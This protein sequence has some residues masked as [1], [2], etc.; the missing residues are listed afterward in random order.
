MNSKIIDEFER[1]IAFI[2]NETDKYITE[3]DTKAA[4]RN[5]FRIRQLS[6]V[7]GILKKYPTKLT[8]ENFKELDDIP[9][10]GKGSINRIKEILEDGKLSEIG[11]FVDIKK[12]K[13]KSLEALEE[14]VGVGRSKALELYNQGI[15]DVKILKQ[16]IKS[17]KI[18]VN[19]KVKLGL[20]YYGKYKTN[21][22][23]KEVTKIEKL[24]K[25]QIEKMNK[26][27]ELNEKNKY[28]LQICGS[29]RR[30]KPFSNDIDVLISK[31]GSKS[32]KK[33]LM[34]FVKRLK[35]NLKSN[36][37]KP[38]LVDDMTD[39][40]VITKYMGFC[41]Y[42]TNPTR[43][44]DIRFVMDN[45]FHSALLY[46]TGSADL[47]KKMR[48]IAKEKGYKLSEY[49]LFD[50]ITGKEIKTKSERDIFKKLDLEYIVP[51]LR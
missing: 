7:L 3:K 47:N 32:N 44:I 23:R 20:K 9:G 12:K 39:G 16:K 27:Y 49:G 22:P 8:L 14:I 28:Y 33:H 6:K 25:K 18:E 36:N 2:R 5:N 29:Y 21:I 17:G 31:V 34:K 13:K 48:Q 42:K 51:R 4:N 10:I 38:L 50:I 1:L 30:E 35:K 41:K 37:N 45:D 19:D 24:L 43:R 46:F 15:T 26:K 40:E 11:D